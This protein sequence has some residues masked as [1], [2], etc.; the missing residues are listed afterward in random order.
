[1]QGIWRH[2]SGGVNSDRR[3][4]ATRPEKREPFFAQARKKGFAGIYSL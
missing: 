2:S 3:L 4:A 1:M